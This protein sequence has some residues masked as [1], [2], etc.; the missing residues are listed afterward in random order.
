MALQNL[1]DEVQ[2]F[3]DVYDRVPNSGE[4]LELDLRTW[5]RIRRASV[6]QF[7]THWLAAVL[8][9]VLNQICTCAWAEQQEDKT[10][11][12]PPTS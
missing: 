11:A 12:M 3:L 4:E 10:H 5:I 9:I 8:F 1:V 7:G 6:S 2:T